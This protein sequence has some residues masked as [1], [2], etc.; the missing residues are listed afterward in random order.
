VRS[1]VVVSCVVAACGSPDSS[2]FE[3]GDV[4]VVNSDGWTFQHRQS[5]TPFVPKGVNYDHDSAEPC[6][7]LLEEYWNDDWA[8]VEGD[9]AEMKK[10]GFNAVRLHLQLPAFMNGPG[11]PNES[12]LGRLDDVVELAHRNGQALLLTGLGNYRPDAVPQWFADLD[13]DAA[14]AAEAAFWQAIARRYPGEPAI[15]GYDLQN[16]PVIAGSDVEQVV[17]DPLVTCDPDDE[18][19]LPERG[20]SYVHF[21]FRHAGPRWTSWRK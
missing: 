10:L 11:A 1:L 12:A 5:K 14:M 21:H 18:G 13:D 7:R 9:F 20:L 15:L 19:P 4:I 16:E 2:S 8:S 6:E 17:S 3:H